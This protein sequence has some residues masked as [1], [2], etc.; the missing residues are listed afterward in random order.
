MIPQSKNSP[1]KKTNQPYHHGNVKG[2]LI[3]AA[4]ELLKTE[5]VD[6]LSLRR[7]AKEI[8][9]TPTAVYNHFSDKD[10]LI[11]AIKMESFEQFNNYLEEKCTDESDPEQGLAELGYAYYMFSK[12]FPSQFEVLFSYAL[13]AEA[14]TD[15]LVQTACRSEE[16]LKSQLQGI[17]K[18]YEVEFDEDSVAKACIM[19]W[20]NIHGLV[21][22]LSGGSIEGT[23]R[24]QNWPEKYLELDNERVRQIISDQIDVLV[25]G[26]CSCNCFKLVA[27]D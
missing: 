7:L 24:C 23:A 19:A 11:A 9:I 15:E 17:F 13:P 14:M 5:K 12:E 2:A 16:Q 26:M 27:S 1:V 21:L 25:K 22:L 20:S 10:A 4:K 6:S 3:A 18:K 8:G